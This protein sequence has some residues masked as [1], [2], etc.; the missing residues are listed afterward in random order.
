MFNQDQGIFDRPGTKQALLLG[1][2]LLLIAAVIA[3]L[4]LLNFYFTSRLTQIQNLALQNNQ[5]LTQIENFLNDF[6]RQSQPVEQPA[7][8]NN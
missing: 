1:V 8:S 4:V 6:S 5:R 2:I 7:P 3:L